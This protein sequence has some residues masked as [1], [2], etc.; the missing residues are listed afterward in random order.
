MTRVLLAALLALAL[1]PTSAP[2]QS[3]TIYAM[4]VCHSLNRGTTCAIDPERFAYL[5]DC[6]ARAARRMSHHP[7]GETTMSC[8][9][10]TVAAW[11]PAE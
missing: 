1:C 2:A 5:P 3:T 10:S 11:E 7:A 8:V 9:R 4:R 6:K